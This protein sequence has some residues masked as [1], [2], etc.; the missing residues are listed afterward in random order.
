MADV[1]QGLFGTLNL[2][3]ETRRYR[4]FEGN[5][6]EIVLLEPSLLLCWTVLFLACIV[7]LAILSR[8][9]KAY[10]VVK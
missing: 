6:Q 1:V 2:A 3:S 9:V 4:D 8:K 5:I 10:E 7:C